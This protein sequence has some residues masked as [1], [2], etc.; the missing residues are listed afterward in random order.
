[1]NDGLHA[2]DLLPQLS[3]IEGFVLLAHN[4]ARRQTTI[5]LTMTSVYAN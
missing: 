3:H 1:M 5:S 2:P 4:S